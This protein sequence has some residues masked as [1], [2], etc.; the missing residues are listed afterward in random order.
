MKHLALIAVLT[1][2]CWDRFTLLDPTRGLP[3]ASKAQRDLLSGRWS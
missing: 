3:M 1:G 2:W